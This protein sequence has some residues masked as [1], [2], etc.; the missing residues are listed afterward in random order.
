MNKFGATLCP[1]IGESPSKTYRVREGGYEKQSLGTP[2]E[3]HSP[4]NKEASNLSKD[5]RLKF[6]QEVESQRIKLRS[7]SEKARS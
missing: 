6:W 5:P 2:H 1:E 4:K 3:A 7:E